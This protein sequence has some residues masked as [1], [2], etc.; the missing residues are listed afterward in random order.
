LHLILGFIEIFSEGHHAASHGAA[1]ESAW[2]PRV[3]TVCAAV[4]PALG[5]AIYGIRSQG[6]LQRIPK[7]SEAMSAEL[8]IIQDALT[9][10]GPVLSSSTLGQAAE[11]VAD[12][13]T[14]EVLDWRIVFQERPLVL[15]G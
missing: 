5:A 15:P 9:R 6:E 4:L 13:M 10:A 2:L 8:G 14:A 1:I 12:I 11:Q 7:R 3:L